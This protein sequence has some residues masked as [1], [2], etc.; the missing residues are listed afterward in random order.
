MFLAGFLSAADRQLFNIA[1]INANQEN[2]TK[3][4]CF[5]RCECPVMQAEPAILTHQAPFCTRRTAKV[6][7][8][9]R[10]MAAA[11][12]AVTAR[13]LVLVAGCVTVRTHGLPAGVSCF[14]QKTPV[15]AVWCRYGCSLRFAESGSGQG[16]GHRGGQAHSILPCRY[17]GGHGRQRRN[18]QNPAFHAPCQRRRLRSAAGQPVRRAQWAEGAWCIRRLRSSGCGAR[19]G[20]ERAEHLRVAADTAFM[21]L[22]S[23]PSNLQPDVGPEVLDQLVDYA[24]EERCDDLGQIQC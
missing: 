20:A 14:R 4:C 6:W 2:A 1:K 22:D 21:N 19:S 10:A 16:S 13:G 18:G 5:G 9:A 23:R 11:N 24:L 3:I 7:C 8:F 15:A 12:A 17:L